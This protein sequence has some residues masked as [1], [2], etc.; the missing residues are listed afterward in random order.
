MCNEIPNK[1]E[2]VI[3]DWVKNIV[4]VD[5][6]TKLHISLPLTGLVMSR[7]RPHLHAQV[8]TMQK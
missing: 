6:K 4:D 2:A 3:F 5:S 7:V 1:T 8:H